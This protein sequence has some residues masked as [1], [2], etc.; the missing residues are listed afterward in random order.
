MNI[1]AEY[2]PTEVMSMHGLEFQILT[3]QEDSEVERDESS[4]DICECGNV[5]M[6]CLGMNWNDFL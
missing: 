2:S 4:Q 6:D 5:C 1:W 3:E